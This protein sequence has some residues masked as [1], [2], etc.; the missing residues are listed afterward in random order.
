M[1]YRIN[2][3]LKIRMIDIVENKNDFKKNATES[4][5]YGKYVVLRR[6]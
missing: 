3:L 4:A 6:N 2:Q 1:I 5:H